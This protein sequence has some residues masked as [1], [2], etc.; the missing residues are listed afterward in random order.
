MQPL[1]DLP[2]ITFQTRRDRFNACVCGVVLDPGKVSPWLYSYSKQSLDSPRAM[3]L[4]VDRDDIEVVFRA[5]WS[6]CEGAYLEDGQGSPAL[7][8]GHRSERQT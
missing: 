3:S 7:V 6:G 4:G 8:P 5:V 1:Y 2:R